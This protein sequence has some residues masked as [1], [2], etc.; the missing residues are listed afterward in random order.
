MLVNDRRDLL[1]TH[2]RNVALLGAWLWASRGCAGLPAA[3]APTA[4]EVGRILPPGTDPPPQNGKPR[5][6]PSTLPRFAIRTRVLPRDLFPHQIETPLTRET[7]FATPPYSMGPP[8]L[9]QSSF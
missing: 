6:S 3:P 8:P 1:A 9:F 2:L 4:R 7:N 5:K